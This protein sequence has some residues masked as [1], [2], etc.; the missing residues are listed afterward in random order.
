MR[1]CFAA[2]AASAGVFAAAGPAR[3]DFAIRFQQAGFSDV[4]VSDG[5]AG[6][7]DPAA[8]QIA[9]SGTFG[10]FALQLATSVTNSPGD[11]TGGLLT[12]GT[13]TLRNTG[14][15][16]ASITLTAS[17]DGFTN[18]LGTDGVRFE[19]AIGGTYGRNNDATDGF[20]YQSYLNDD[21]TLFST[22]G[23]TAGPLAG[24]KGTDGQVI[25]FD[26]G[27]AAT[28]GNLY[29]PPYSVTSVV[30]Y[31]ASNE[32]GNTAGFNARAE[33]IPQFGQQAV[34][35]PAGLALA[36]VAVPLLGAMRW[37]VRRRPAA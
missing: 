10:S 31:S 27:P 19:Y 7:L 29:A 16:P 12:I 4:T 23:A 13:N 32:A 28:T 14:A 5:G 36:A 24:Q 9:F 33:V 2:L 26:L 22:A 11:P 18:P 1:L 37:R 21:N 8:G 35:A 34:P 3:A 17:A 25:P 30:T 6:D 20:T 15:G